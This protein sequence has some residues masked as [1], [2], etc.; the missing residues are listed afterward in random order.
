M[1]YS[2]KQLREQLGNLMRSS[3]VSGS[4]DYTTVIPDDTA[5]IKRIFYKAKED[6]NARDNT[7][8]KFFIFVDGGKQQKMPSRQVRDVISF[9]VMGIFKKNSL[10]NVDPSEQAE[11]FVDDMS[12]FIANND[13]LGGYVED[14]GMGEFTTDSG[15]ADPE[16]IAFV[17]VLIERRRQY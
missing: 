14:A 6:A 16:A 3:F 9:D 8:P 13:T 5:S 2:L 4:T 1:S 10:V 17:K 11:S 12:K 15:T 7:Y